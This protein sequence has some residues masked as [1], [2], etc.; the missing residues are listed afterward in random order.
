MEEVEW[1]EWRPFG[2]AIADAPRVPGVYMF[3]QVASPS[4][5]YVGSAGERRGDGLR[6][7]LRVYASGKGLASGL[8]EAVFD[9]ALADPEWV[10][11]RLREIEAGTPRRAKE[12][13][14]L[15]IEWA[16]F[17]VRWATTADKKSAEALEDRVIAQ[18]EGLWNRRRTVVLKLEDLK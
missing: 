8:G 17:E 4:V 14:R 18:H 6:G 10:R 16:G 3:R 1:S 13:G 5:V 9:R 7:R 2:E 12:W 15:A 11:A